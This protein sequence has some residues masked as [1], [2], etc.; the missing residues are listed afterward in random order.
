[1]DT[2]RLTQRLMA[3]FLG[4]L[5]D[6]LR[7]LERDLLA[8]EKHP[9]PGVRTGLFATLFRTAHSLKGAARSVGVEPLEAAGHRLEELFAGGR[10]GRIPVDTAYFNRVLPIVDEIRDTGRSLHTRVGKPGVAFGGAQCEQ[11]PS[12]VPAMGD[13]PAAAS[14]A[15]A[16][17]APESAQWSGVVR[18]AAS[19]LDALLAQSGELLAVRHRAHAR[20]EAA[21]A[22]HDATGGW[23]KE[24]RRIEQQFAGLVQTDAAPG[25]AAAAAGE[26]R[27]NE[28]GRR[29]AERLLGQHKSSMARFA[30][31]MQRLVAELRADHRSLELAAQRI[32]TEVHRVRMLPFSEACEGLDRM[33]RDLAASAGKRAEV[34]VRGGEIEIDRSVL[35][36]LKDPLIHLVRNAVDHGIEPP[37]VRRASGKP[38]AGR[39]TV[40]A[41]VRAGRLEIAIGDDGRGLDLAAIR[42][43][44]N[45]KGMAVPDD[46]QELVDRIFASGFS[47]STAVT[48]VSGRGVGLEVVQSRIKAMRGIVDVAF[49]PGRGTRFTLRVA[50]TLTS[51]R[52]LIVEAGRQTFALDT[53]GV[54]RVVRIGA[55]DIRSIE[56]REVVMVD[57]RP[58]SV[59]TLARLLGVPERIASAAG[60]K[61]PAVVLIDGNRKAALV[62]DDIQAEREVMLRPLG[63]R[64]RGVHHVIGPTVLPDGHVALVLN[65]GDLVDSVRRLAP[66]S[67]VV[68][69]MTVAKPAQSR[70][71]LLVDDSITTRTLEKTILEAAG[72]E[73]LIATD[74][75]EAWQVLLERGADLVVSDVEMPRMDG[76]SL[77]ETI[78]SSRRFRELPVILMTARDNDADRAHGLKVGANAYLFK[79]AFDQRELLATI[80]QIL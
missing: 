78:R 42:D 41:A 53:A 30:R 44:L 62:V 37:P 52:A 61:R 2:D 32:D 23:Q 35:E 38:D 55:S 46:E 5:E 15:P 77:T 66:S 4:E 12:V 67:S 63:R 14:V 24:W 1:M 45:S 40:A 13:A 18:V 21:R 11:S 7:A 16:D 39:V 22:L 9:D 10:D 28:S 47:T 17:R 70:R 26:P 36:G 20:A 72:Y 80:G 69:S 19:K 60:E 79:S 27:P 43:R 25:M 71:L 64:L 50:L 58:V 33:V 76:F 65:T 56:G 75:A 68:Q 51:V 6:H 73:V 49:E 29:Q 3:T 57:A 74:G 31:E 48:A 59:V 34:V 54:D 8:L